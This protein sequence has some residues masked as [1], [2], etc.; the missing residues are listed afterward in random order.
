MSKKF[1]IFMFLVMFIILLILG[2]QIFKLSLER[3]QNAVFLEL[4]NAK[5]NNLK[6]VDVCIFT[7]NLVKKCDFEIDNLPDDFVFF[8]TNQRLYYKFMQDNFNVVLSKKCVYTKSLLNTLIFFVSWF[9]V[10]FAILFL[11]Y[12]NNIK[13]LE[14]HKNA[15]NTFFNDAMHEL[16]TPLG[17]AILN[18]SMLNDSL[19]KKRIKAALNQIKQT[20]DD[21]EFYIKNPYTK[22]EL[23]K[24]NFSKILK[25]RLEQF[26]TILE[27]KAIK[28][29]YVIND[30]LYVFLSEV[31]L[32]RIIDNNISNAIKYT[33]T[34]LKIRL[35]KKFDKI[36]FLIYDNGLGI[37]DT[38][39]IFNRYTRDDKALGGFG[40]GLNIVKNI[41]LKFDI[42]Y[43]AKNT[44]N[45]ALFI[46]EF[47]EYKKLILDN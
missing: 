17:V 38:K 41:C 16:K 42:K 44:L 6:N 13:S 24:L 18:L 45:G 28:I 30:D 8:K 12:K 5:S 19:A 14:W 2:N 36:Y 10:F 3:D 11:I 4:V 35:F 33:K 29:D 9:F 46:Y 7:D 47:K 1:E 31:E 32:V 26:S 23:E 15:M 37:K 43:K 27:L 39:K 20:Y 40:I 34:N 22:Y 21:V 25:E